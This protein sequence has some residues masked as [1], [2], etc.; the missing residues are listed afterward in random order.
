VIARLR[1]VLDIPPHVKI[2]LN[3][4]QLMLSGVATAAW[5]NNIARITPILT[6]ITDINSQ[7]L[8]TYTAAIE[9]YLQVPNTADFVYHDGTL[10]FTG[11]APFAWKI[12][13][14]KKIPEL[15]FIHTV[16]WKALEITEEKRLQR[17]QKTLEK[18]AIYFKGEVMSDKNLPKLVRLLREM[19][20]LCDTLNQTM[21][22][23]ITGYTDGLDTT[24][25]NRLLAETR[26]QKM[27]DALKPFIFSIKM[28][29]AR[30]LSQTHH[31]DPLQ[32]KVGFSVTFNQK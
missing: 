18:Q 16:Q 12:T 29:R 20:T 13:A 30:Q 8:Q 32:R 5:I 21:T 14:D 31:G 10:L 11:I 4:T 27:M 28:K 1:A 19:K 26:A 15:G 7:K 22:L 17:F 25:Y 23:T 3:K 9:A 2:Q 24:D 6:G